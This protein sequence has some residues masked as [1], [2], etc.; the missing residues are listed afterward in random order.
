M[1]RSLLPFAL[2]LLSLPLSVRAGDDKKP[3]LPGFKYEEIHSG[4]GMTAMDFDSEGRL[5]VCEKWGRVLVFQPKGKGD[6]E[7]PEVFA[8]FH[9]QVNPEGE[10]GLLG[11]A[12]D[13]GFAKNHYLYVFY[14]AQAEQRLVRLTAD[15]DFKA[16]VPGQELVLLDGLPRTMT[17]HK[18][19]DIHFHPSDP[20]AIFLIL[21]DDTKRELSPDLDYYNGKLLR[22]DTSNGKGL[23]D[24]P[25][26]DGKPDSIRSRVW[27][28]GFRNPFRF[29]FV[30]GRPADAVYVSENGD[31]TDRIARVQRG[32]DG[33]WGTDGDKGLLKPE[34]PHTSVLYTTKPCMTSI[35]IAPKGPFAPDGPVLYAQNWFTK[36]LMRWKLAGKD[37][38]EMAAIPSDDGKAFLA[39]HQ[40]VHATFGPDGAL[41]LT[42]TYYSESKGGNFKLSRIVAAGAGRN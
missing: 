11:I 39:E 35:A 21:G 15:K 22:L 19:G 20:K 32:G 6:F 34:D 30:P 14:T 33:G 3:V 36:D 10:S 16:A 40:T 25:F 27:A 8:D 41:Y 4:N 2:A 23:K 9:E 17:N 18:A 5:F 29:A 26:Y 28:K 42:Q 24:N 1:K 13:P 37:L 7:K 12:L 31:G 38:A